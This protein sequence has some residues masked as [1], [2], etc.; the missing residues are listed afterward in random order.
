MSC[1]AFPV[2]AAPESG[3]D[4]QLNQVRPKAAPW[5]RVT[6]FLRAPQLDADS[7]RRIAPLRVFVAAMALA[8]SIG[9]VLFLRADGSTRSHLPQ[10]APAPTGEHNLALF[11]WG[12]TLRASSYHREWFAQHHPIFLIDGRKDPRELEKWTTQLDDERPWVEITWREPRQLSRVVI[13]HGGFREQ[14]SYTARRY[15]LWCIAQDGT[16]KSSLDV[17]DNQQAVATHP[18]ACDR[19]RGLQIS[20]AR[21]A[22]DEQVRIYEI[23]AWGR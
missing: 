21:S 20:F 8:W 18:L 23:E 2:E 15:R 13:F 9:A 1:R 7:A 22:P 3:P 12:P 17:L 16:R 10:V 5:S 14:A 4:T 19:A 11:R 6:R